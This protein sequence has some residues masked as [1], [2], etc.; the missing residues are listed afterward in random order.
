MIFVPKGKAKS[1][2]GRDLKP[3]EVKK[4]DLSSWSFSFPD[5]AQY[6]SV[7]A[8]WR[9]EEAAK[10]MEVKAGDGE[11]VLRLPKHYADQA[12]AET[13]AKARFKKVQQEKAT[14]SLSLAVGNPFV[15]AETP[16]TL[17]DMRPEVAQAK[18]MVAEVRHTIS[19]GYLLTIDIARAPVLNTSF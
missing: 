12:E 9:N 7:I 4:E 11:P 13:A 8:V 19:A 15:L 16:I 14:G 6:G 10:D 5:R 3:V 2:S 18:W 17:P 1:A